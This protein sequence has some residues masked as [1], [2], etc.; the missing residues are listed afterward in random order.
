VLLAQIH[1]DLSRAAAW[2]SP[3]EYLRGLLVGGDAAVADE[4]A[5]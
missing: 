1:R 2:H 5:G 4:L 3:A